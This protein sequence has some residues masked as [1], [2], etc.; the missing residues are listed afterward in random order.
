MADEKKATRKPPF[1]DLIRLFYIIPALQM[2]IFTASEVAKFGRTE[3][4]EKFFGKMWDFFSGRCGKN[5]REN[6]EMEGRAAII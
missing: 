6:V 3:M 2:L 4:L 1:L 5:F